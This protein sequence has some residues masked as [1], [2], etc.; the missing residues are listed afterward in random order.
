M[1]SLAGFTQQAGGSW[2][3][4]HGALRC[5]SLLV[6]LHSHSWKRWSQDWNLH[7]SESRAQEVSLEPHGLKKAMGHSATK[8]GAWGP[9]L[10]GHAHS[11]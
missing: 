3:V 1:A 11:G 9:G 7:L 8:C 4:S 5:P 6:W 10:L 2:N